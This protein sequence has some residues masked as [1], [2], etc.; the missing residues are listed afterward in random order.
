MHFFWAQEP[1]VGDN[2]QP[3]NVLKITQELKVLSEIDHFSIFFVKI[4]ILPSIQFTQIDSTSLYIEEVQEAG[5][6]P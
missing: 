3:T 4:S 2:H 6:K 5:M 1:N